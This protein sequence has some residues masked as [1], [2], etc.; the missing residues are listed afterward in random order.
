MR[1]RLVRALPVMAIAIL[2]LLAAPSAHAQ[3]TMTEWWLYS[4]VTLGDQILLP[5]LAVVVVLVLAFLLRAR[6][7]RPRR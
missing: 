4:L 7:P 6:T 1:S 2:W 5:V 3:H